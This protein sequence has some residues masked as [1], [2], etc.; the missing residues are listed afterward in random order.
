MSYPVTGGS[1][2]LLGPF[3]EAD[4]EAEA[5]EP[6]PGA[7]AGRCSYPP[8]PGAFDPERQSWE[9]FSDVYELTVPPGHFPDAAHLPSSIEEAIRQVLEQVP[10]APSDPEL[11]PR[12]YVRPQREPQV[13]PRGRA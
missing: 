11:P 12:A 13:K 6:P 1:S 8:P 4:L 9:D 7:D 3:G 2:T 10:R 5:F